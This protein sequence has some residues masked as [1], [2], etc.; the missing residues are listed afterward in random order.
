MYKQLYNIQKN[1]VIVD[2]DYLRRLLEDSGVNHDDIINT[3]ITLNNKIIKK[4]K[5]IT[6]IISVKNICMGDIIYIGFFKKL[7]D[8]V[9]DMFKDNLETLYFTDTTQ[10]FRFLF[11]HISCFLNEDVSGKIK[12]DN[13][14][15]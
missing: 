10:I 8:G 5:L 4:Y 7:L 3:F 6:Y 15:E 12:F 9:Q 11:N 2:M 1:T 14:I 13:D